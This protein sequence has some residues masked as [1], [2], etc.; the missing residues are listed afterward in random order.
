VEVSKQ[1]NEEVVGGR[2][3]NGGGA[4][5]CFQFNFHQDLVAGNFL[6]V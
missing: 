2:G 3:E 6:D 5:C 4:G 1:E